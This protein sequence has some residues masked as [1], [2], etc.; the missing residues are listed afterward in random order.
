M[1]LPAPVNGYSHVLCVLDLFTNYLVTRPM[2]TRTKEETAQNLLQIIGEFGP[3]SF[4]QT[5]DGGEFANLVLQ[6]ML[7]DMHVEFHISSP[8]EHGS[9]G[10]IERAIRTLRFSIRKLLNGKMALWDAILPLATLY[11]NITT[12]SLHNTS[13]Y[14]L[15]FAR[16][17]N[18]NQHDQPWI[19][20]RDGILEDENIDPHYDAWIQHQFDMVSNIYPHLREALVDKREKQ[21]E[22]FDKKHKIVDTYKVGDMVLS[23]DYQ[24][25]SKDEPTR[26]GPFEV[27]EVRESGSYV[28][29]DGINDP[30]VRHASSLRLWNDPQFSS[31]SIISLSTYQLFRVH[32]LLAPSIS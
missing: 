24:K 5:D 14:V 3:P 28:I 23:I 31:S 1:E 30:L 17:Y 13:P 6:S 7:E 11:Y 20:S 29:S 10:R 27:V 18:N 16:E 9:T 4:I 32:P 21:H 25:R 19:P 26:V 2:K 12:K 8:H 15:M 22:H